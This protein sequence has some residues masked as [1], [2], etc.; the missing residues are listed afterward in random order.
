MKM[1]SLVLIWPRFPSNFSCGI[2][3]S[4]Q[5]LTLK[6]TVTDTP[7]YVTLVHSAPHI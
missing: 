5:Y 3:L 4:V 1:N 7:D 6:S 2:Y